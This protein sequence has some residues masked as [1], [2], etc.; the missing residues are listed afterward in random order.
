MAGYLAQLDSR[1][2]QRLNVLS[3]SVGAASGIGTTVIDGK[4]GQYAFGIGGGLL[5]AGLGLLTLR[6]SGHTA[7]FAHP[8]NLLTDV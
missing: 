2:T 7:T 6:Q 3:I 4:P 1:R 5:A 8:R